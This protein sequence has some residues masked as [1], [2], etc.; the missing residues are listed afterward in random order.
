[1]AGLDERD[2]LNEPLGRT[3]PV[4]RPLPYARLAIGLGVALA[5]GLAVFL[6][7]TDD[8]MGGEPYAVA[9]IDRRPVAVV[10]AEIGCSFSRSEA[11]AS[12]PM[13]SPERP[14][15]WRRV[16]SRSFP[17]CAFFTA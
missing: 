10:A 16:T 17:Q 15:N 3:A 2:E 1:M 8:H 6:V 4:R 5:I 7:E 11:K 14:K 13:L 9:S 12:A